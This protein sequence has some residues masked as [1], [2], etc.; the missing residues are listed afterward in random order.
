MRIWFAIVSFAVTALMCV[1]VIVTTVATAIIC[2]DYKNL[3]TDTIICVFA[4]V[5]ALG[6]LIG[7]W[8][9]MRIKKGFKSR[10]K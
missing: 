9:L 3:L 10:F 2:P 7:I 1:A 8:N 6:I 4:G 5:C